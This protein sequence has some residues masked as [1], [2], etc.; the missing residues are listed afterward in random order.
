MKASH[1][2]S[3]RW[4]V[5]DVL[6]WTGRYLAGKGV[7]SPRLD[8]EVLLAH[9]L[10]TDRL[11]LYL[12]LDRP[13][14]LHE[15]DRYRDLVRRRAEREPVALITGTKEFWSLPFR[16][17]PGVLIPRPDTEILVDVVL[18]EIKGIASPRVMEVGTGSGAVA[19]SILHENP[20]ATVLATDVDTLSLQIA[21]LNA[22]EA[23]VNGSLDCAASDL[24]SAIRP[25]RGFDVIC[26][27]PPYIPT[28]NIPALEREIR[29]F[30]PQRA[31]DGGPD[32]LDVIR[33]LSVHARDYLK[34][35]GAIILEVGDGQADSV[36]D[37]LSDLGGFSAIYKFLDLAGKLRVVKGK[38]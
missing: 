33:R 7:S 22:K 25:G 38:V 18:E 32:G 27:N 17:A 16:V 9:S 20:K 28:E 29:D 31:L 23:H 5:K 30:E 13:L 8:A 1:G 21:W 35:S 6:D 11:H 26:S 36:A 2:T 19:V 3:Q 24:F 14:L 12:N 4:T 15:R 34:D 10:G 37:I